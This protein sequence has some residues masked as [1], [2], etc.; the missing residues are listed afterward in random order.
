MPVL[1]LG[2]QIDSIVE[3]E[4]KMIT[5]Q[6]GIQ[7]GVFISAVAMISGSIWWAAIMTA[8][9]DMVLSQLS[10]MQSSAVAQDK[11]V[12]Q[13]KSRVEHIELL[14]SGRAQEADRRITDL[15][16]RFEAH[17]VKP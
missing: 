1:I 11:M 9:M 5:K 3:N 12:D 8:K 15:E 16:K 2:E 10:S 14:G 4:I 7:M 17:I 13:L 6:T